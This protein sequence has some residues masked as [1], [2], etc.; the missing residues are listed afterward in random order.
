MILYP[1]IIV[2][3]NKN[4]TRDNYIFMKPNIKQ[5]TSVKCSFLKSSGLNQG[6]W[7]E[8]LI[9]SPATLTLDCFNELKAFAVDFEYPKLPLTLKSPKRAENDVW[10]EKEDLEEV[11]FWSLCSD[12]H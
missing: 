8:T 10:V 6:S 1:V 2:I 7:T 12:V 3:H 11:S 4:V 5:L 9:S